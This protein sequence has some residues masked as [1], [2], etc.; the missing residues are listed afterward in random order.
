MNTGDFL[1]LILPSA[2]VYYVVWI[3]EAGAPKH[4]P[5]TST[6]EAADKALLLSSQ[7][8]N[9]YHACAS[10][11]QAS[12][13]DDNGKTCWRTH[14]NALLVR[15][16]WLDLDVKNQYA[17][18]KD[19]L[20]D[21]KRFC[22][23]TGIQR[24]NVLVDSG[25]G[26]HAYW[27]F[28]R[29][30]PKDSWVKM[31]EL[32]KSVAAHFKLGV[33]DTTRTADVASVLRP[34]GTVNDKT[35]KGLG[36][37]QVK[38]TGEPVTALVNVS[39]WVEK[40]RDIKE[41]YG[42]KVLQPKASGKTKSIAAGMNAAILGGMEYPESSA[43]KIA[44]R[45]AQIGN[46]RDFKGVGQDYQIWRDCIGVLKH[47]VEGDALIHE[48]SSGH[49]DY[50]P[51][52]CQDVIEKWNAG[53]TL[54]EK[55][56]QDGPGICAGCAQSVNSPIALG[57]LAPAAA[58]EIVDVTTG[59]TED[60]PALPPDV[61]E[62][63]RFVKGSGMEARTEDKDGSEVWE[64]FTTTIPYITAYYKD[65]TTLKWMYTIKTWLRSNTWDTAHV[66]AGIIAAGGAAMLKELSSYCM[67]AP[68]Y[69]RAKHLE[70]Y[71]KLWAE[72]TRMH[73]AETEMHG[74]FGWKPDGSFVVGNTQYLPEGGTRFVALTEYLQTYAPQFEVKGNLGRYIELIDK[75]YNRHNHEPH[76]F[77]WLGGFASVLLPL[78]HVGFM[79]GIIAAHSN[80]SGAG[81][82]TAQQLATGIWGEATRLTGAESTTENAMYGK[83]EMR[84]HLPM[85]IDE[86]TPWGG[87][88]ASDF[89]YRYSQGL[90]KD[91]LKQDGSLRDNK[92]AGWTNIALLSSNE[93][94]VSHIIA[95]YVNPGPRIYRIWEYKFTTKSSEMLGKSEGQRVINELLSMQ[96]VAGDAFIRYV[97]T[98]RDEI[99]SRLDA[100]DEEF[101][102][103]LNL[104]QEARF[105]LKIAACI[106]VAH[107]ITTTLGLQKFDGGA[108]KAWVK[109][110][111]RDMHN[112]VS[113]SHV[114]MA[115][116]FGDMIA[117]L[118]SGFLMTAIEGDRRSKDGKAATIHGYPPRG[119]VTGRVIIND[120]RVLVSIHAIR[121]WCKEN[122]TPVDEMIEVA[123]ARGWYR[124]RFKYCLGK[125]LV[126]YAIPQ[127]Q[128]IE[129]DWAAFAERVHLVDVNAVEAARESDEKGADQAV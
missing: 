54:C 66:E 56:K 18:K 125:G 5:C 124:G 52:I 67:I 116:L 84:R 80:Q 50:Q 3:K 112:R 121:E 2:G 76:Q 62:R 9:V 57:R 15:S 51:G 97:V 123:T 37:K 86:I 16:Q 8:K 25:N 26:V 22:D 93:S 71:M 102:T 108:L 24:P 39:A 45:C 11:A 40:L 31:A 117:E 29:D 91:R 111:L 34:I 63:F 1:K 99:A 98:H 13:V 28:N 59:E 120:N 47:C 44:E 36:I 122:N 23:T 69:G 20:L 92:D 30:I 27:V 21:L 105:W 74:Y 115:G 106:W 89:A 114:D 128:V 35:H 129:L 4:Y 88:K 41:E 77:T 61:E 7:G 53:P 17:T 81:K 90:P 94:M 43:V 119:A 10:Y 96:G 104:N 95:N 60:I 85:L 87:K 109:R 83:A 32:F 110:S 6:E 73:T 48:W 65:T 79:G 101:T 55:F 14:E 19:A 126:D 72:R 78:H 58:R 68:I 118:H 46:F 107:E 82:T 127:Q 33:D 42:I 113:D 12:Y 70:N 64:V 38:L 75:L 100:A 103:V 49:E